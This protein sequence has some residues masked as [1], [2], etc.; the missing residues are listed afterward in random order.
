MNLHTTARATSG[1]FQPHQSTIRERPGFLPDP[2]CDW[3]DVAT[4]DLALIDIIGGVTGPAWGVHACP[5]CVKNEGLT[6]L[7]DTSPAER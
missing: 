7:A 5:P 4:D 2:R 1:V 3:C 6:A